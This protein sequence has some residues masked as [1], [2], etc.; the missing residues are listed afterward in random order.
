MKTAGLTMMEKIFLNDNLGVLQFPEW[1]TN[2]NISHFI[3]TRSGGVSEGN[4]ASMNPGLYTTDLPENIVENRRI[5]CDAL[6]IDPCQ[7]ITPHQV[8]SDRIVVIDRTWLE[9]NESD[10]KLSLEGVDALM[11]NVP[12]VFVTV[13]TADCVPV[14]LYASDKQAVAAVHAGWRGT[15][16]AIVQKTIRKMVAVYGCDVS[17]LQVAIGPSISLQS[18]EVGAELVDVFRASAL[19]APGD[20]ETLFWLNPAIRKY[21]IDLW[22][23]NRLLSYYEGVREPHIFQ[24]DL[25]TYE[26]A[27]ELFSARRLGINSG[28]ILSGISIHR[29]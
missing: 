13:S 26:H 12:D 17:F 8:H 16:A 14:L 9:Q 19:W 11:T 10:R 1:M 29:S 3:T 22:R 20:V 7:L 21:H 24:S 5:L 25:C 2:C 4:F 18:F 6:R 28:R 15:V 27:D 23:A